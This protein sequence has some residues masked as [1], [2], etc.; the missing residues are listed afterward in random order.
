MPTIKESAQNYEPLKT[1]TVAELPEISTDLDVRVKDG[2]K[3]KKG[4]D[5]SY[6]YILVANVEYRVP[7]SVLNSLK[8]ILQ[9]TPGLKKFKVRSSGTG[10]DTTYTV[11][12]LV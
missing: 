12:P 9:D 6:K 4:E 2:L 1:K 3:N 10:F 5:W 8:M 11:I 7:D